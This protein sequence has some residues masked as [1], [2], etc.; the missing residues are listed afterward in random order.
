MDVG[1]NLP[2]GADLLAVVRRFEPVL[3]F[4]AGELFFPM[5]ADDYLS[6]AAL[7]TRN[8]VG[9]Q[10]SELLVDFGHL[11]PDLLSTVALARPREHLYLRYAPKELD[12]HELKAWRR[13]SDRP[14]FTGVTRLAAVGLLGR[15]IDSG[16]RLSLVLRGRV[17]GGFTAASQRQYASTPARY[18]YHAHV[19]ADGGYLVVQYWFLYA[20]NDWRSSF[21]GVNDHEADWEQVTVY[22][23]PIDGSGVDAGSPAGWQ[24][25]WVAFSSHDEVG[26][27]LRRRADDP[28]ITWVEGNHAVVNAGA[29]SHSGAYLAGDYLVRV[30]PPVLKRFIAAV[31][32]IRSMLMPWTRRTTQDG[33]GI[34]FVDYR[35]GDGMAIGPGT[36][37]EWTPILIDGETPWVRDFR[38]LWGF[39]TQDPF[40]GERAPAGP[41]YERSGSIRTSW[42]GPVGWAGLDKVPPTEAA[43]AGAESRRLDELDASITELQAGIAAAQDELRATR[44][45]MDLLP[46]TVTGGRR[47]D[48]AA[49]ALATRETEVAALRATLRD[50][51]NERDQLRHVPRPTPLADPHAHLPH[52]AVPDTDL[53][54]TTGALL[55]FWSAASLTVLL[56][57]LGLALL[58]DWG[59]VLYVTVAA[60]I[61]VMALDALFRRHL[62]L[63]LAGLAALFAVIYV[64][65]LLATHTRTAFGVI[66]IV[67]ALAIGIAN[68]RNLFSRR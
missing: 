39:D 14:K 32:A 36:G 11:D 62:V 4:T 45:G 5:S 27:E 7:W 2:V 56:L 22:L 57:L 55:Q 38:G 8:P 46:G 52:R 35:R 60:V 41:R 66:A 59:P 15:I 29:G 65:W 54:P 19:T 48:S 33:I 31:L 58:L 61:I 50:A 26:D 37:N 20:M 21:G 53:K 24:V 17:P 25:A 18:A 3:R 44:V 16:M 67:F 30:Q 13:R 64:I 40:G 49:A 23:A 9:R 47:H 63:Y 42:G 1:Q 28:D 51:V 34:P 12:R 43:R 6:R 10:P 68:L